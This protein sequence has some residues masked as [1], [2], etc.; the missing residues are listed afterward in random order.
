MSGRTKMTAVA[1]FTLTPQASVV[2]QVI[3]SEGTAAQTN[4]AGTITV[5]PGV[6]YIV[7]M[8]IL[9]NDLGS[10][11]ERVVDVTLDGTSIGGC[12]PD[13]H[14]Y[15]CTFFTCSQSPSVSSATGNIAVNLEYAGHS[16]DCDCDKESWECSKEDTVSG[17]T[18][19]TAVAR[20]TLTPQAIP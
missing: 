14:D 6:T 4:N 3:Y 18:K 12:N 9:R 7:S 2:T 17:R 10:S 15:D 1:R 11:S 16:W 20:F 19:M 13:G 5:V 8:E